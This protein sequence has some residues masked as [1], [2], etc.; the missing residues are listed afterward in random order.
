MNFYPA[1]SASSAFPKDG[2]KN[3]DEVV[4]VMKAYAIENNFVLV[5][6]RSQVP[7]L[8]LKCAKGGAYK[9]RR[10]GDEKA[11]RITQTCRVGCPYLLR[12]S[13][14]KKEQKY[15]LLKSLHEKEKYHNHPLSPKELSTLH[16]GRMATVTKEDFIIAGQLFT[17]NSKTIKIQ[18]LLNDE[19][20]PG[21]MLAS[22]IIDD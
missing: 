16:E 5:T 7:I 8:H 22:H 21:K 14:R 2:M 19:S 20:A 3:K 4:N 6:A 9:T 15:Y 10:D 12:F 1:V 13:F 11:K 17:E 18:D